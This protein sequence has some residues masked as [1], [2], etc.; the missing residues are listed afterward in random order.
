MR[1]GEGKEQ[2]CSGWPDESWLGPEV[3][4]GRGAGEG[5]VALGVNEGRWGCGFAGHLDTRQSFYV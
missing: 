2:A 3:V 5:K 4:K 1:R